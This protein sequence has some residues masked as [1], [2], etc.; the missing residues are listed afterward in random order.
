MEEDSVCTLSYEYV[1]QV[2]HLM[3]MHLSDSAGVL[4]Q[5]AYELVKDRDMPLWKIY[6]M[7]LYALLLYN[8][9]Q[10]LD[11]SPLKEHKDSLISLA[12]KVIEM[13]KGTPMEPYSHMAGGRLMVN[14]YPVVP[15]ESFMSLEEALKSKNLRFRNPLPI[16]F[17]GYHTV[18]DTTLYP[19]TITYSLVM[20]RDSLLAKEMKGLL[21]HHDYFIRTKARVLLAYHF[22]ENGLAMS[23]LYYAGLLSDSAGAFGNPH[24]EAWSSNIAGDVVFFF[25]GDREEGHLHYE[26]A[27]RILDSLYMGTGRWGLI[28]PVV[29]NNVGMSE[30]NSHRALQVLR[31]SLK[32]HLELYGE[33]SDAVANVMANIFN[34]MR[35]LGMVDSAAA[36]HKRLLEIRKKVRG[37]KFD[38]MV[39]AETVGLASFYL[40]IGDTT[41]A[42][43]TARAALDSLEIGN[44][45]TE[46]FPNHYMLRRS[47][48]YLILEEYDSALYWLDLLERYSSNR[49]F[50]LMRKIRVYSS[51]RD[52]VRATYTLDTVIN[53]LNRDPHFTSIRRQ[54]FYRTLQ[55]QWEIL[56]PMLIDMGLKS[57][58]VRMSELL[59]ARLLVEDMDL[60]R[61]PVIGSLTRKLYSMIDLQFPEESLSTVERKIFMRIFQKK[62]EF[63]A[64]SEP[65]L[66]PGTA[67]LGYVAGKKRLIG[68]AISQSDTILF[69]KDVPRD[70]LERL[71][72]RLMGSPFMKNTLS[73][74][75]WNILIEP[76]DTFLERFERVAISPHGPLTRLAFPIL[77]DGRKYLVEKPYTTYRVFSLWGFDV[78]CR[79][80]G[81]A[82]ALGRNDY[83]ENPVL[84]RRGIG[85]LKYAEK[86][87]TSVVKLLGGVALTGSEVEEEKLYRIN[88][89]EFPIIHF[90][91]HAIVDSNSMIVL[92]PRR[93]TVP[94]RDN[95]LRLG[96]IYSHLRVG[97]LVVLSGCRTGLGK[98]IN[99]WEGLFNLTRG[100]V[101]TGAH[102][103]ITTKWD[104]NDMASYQ[105]MK[106]MYEYLSK[107]YPVDLALKKAQVYLLQETGLSS[108]VYWGAF[109]LTVFGR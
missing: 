52:T 36:S 34:A 14:A 35:N 4:I 11:A 96:E 53:M 83:G 20:P 38:L 6:L 106:R 18:M 95:I 49:T 28:Y 99:D 48:A 32:L 30:S 63:F 16:D 58:L 60:S 72:D 22:I 66:P 92:G 86:E 15:R 68:Y 103:V 21:H 73:R 85:N 104:I 91:T 76:V 93:D 82:L 39:F 69:Y 54:N 62:K 71:V 44:Y 65:V 51:M 107:G 23:A 100:F 29:L 79:T 46:K 87:A 31:K 94:Y 10:L 25:L 81:P 98:F 7:S 97:K 67:L 78:P 108:P 57:G 27:L 70:S 9:I 77:F 105:L 75:L 59:K 84:H 50:A 3:N 74:T 109:T 43:A 41:K 88:L 55:E 24:I 5:R 2:P 17:G 101:Y 40:E 42:K 12:W 33:N 90:A 47:D 89:D 1:K 64:F 61:D 80:R 13:G 56:L 26:R 8:R 102:C 45:Y 19:S 37:G